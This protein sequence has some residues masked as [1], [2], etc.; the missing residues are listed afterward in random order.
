MGINDNG[1]IVG[2]AWDV[3]YNHRAFLL[4]VP[5]PS[6]MLLFIVGFAVLSQAVRAGGPEGS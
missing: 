4:A 6:P 5:E 1:D 3:H 2:D